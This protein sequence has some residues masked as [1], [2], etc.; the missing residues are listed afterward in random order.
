MEN[1]PIAYCLK[2]CHKMGFFLEKIHGKQLVRMKVEFYQ[3]EHGK[4]W[5]FNVQDV[6]IRT[7]IND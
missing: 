2:V 7:V 4:I 3:D 1:S 5:L 6:W